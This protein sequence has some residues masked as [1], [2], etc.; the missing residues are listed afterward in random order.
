MPTRQ[1]TTDAVE[2]M[3]REVFKNDPEQLR[4]VEHYRLNY[5]IAGLIYGLRTHA[6]LSQ[7][8]LAKRIGTT[9][10]VIS[11]LED[12]DYGGHSL[13]MLAKIASAL[14]H[15]LVLSAKRM[16]TREI[17]PRRRSSTRARTVAR[18]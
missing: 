14:G 10:S 3:K 7:V 5:E 12:A 18:A 16:E 13:S 9:Q 2:I 6:D 1:S 11:R 15:R 17:K 8:E 4:A